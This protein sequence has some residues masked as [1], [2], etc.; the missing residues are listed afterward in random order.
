MREPA[1]SRRRSDS[2]T[3]VWHTW[4]DGAAR[5]VRAAKIGGDAESC[6]RALVH[7]SQR[8]CA[9]VRARVHACG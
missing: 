2:R 9:R 3:C 7:L 8:C 6:A 5:R 1:V 4:S